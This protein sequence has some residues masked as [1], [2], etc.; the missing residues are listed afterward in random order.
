MSEDDLDID[1]GRLEEGIEI[2]DDKIEREEPID[3]I[4]EFAHARVCKVHTPKGVRLEVSSPKRGYQIRLDPVVL[5]AISW[6]NPDMF[7]ELLKT[8]LGPE[9]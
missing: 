6:Q 2:D 3:L 9:E 7:S 5:E 4:N 1:A 8:P